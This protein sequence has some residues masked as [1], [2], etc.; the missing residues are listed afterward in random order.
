MQPVIRPPQ[1]P[2]G[3]GDAVYVIAQLGKDGEPTCYLMDVKI[4]H[5]DSTEEIVLITDITMAKEFPSEADAQQEADDINE[6]RNFNL[7][8]WKK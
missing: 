1:N 8:A 5:G 6:R 7:Q 3:Q 2:Q 4:R